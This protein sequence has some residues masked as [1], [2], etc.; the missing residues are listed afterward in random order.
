MASGQHSNCSKYAWGRAAQV[1]VILLASVMMTLTASAVDRSHEQV[2]KII[3]Q[4]QRADYEGDRSSLK[5]LH[6]KLAPFAEN[7]VLAAPVRYWR[8]FALWRRAINGFNDNVA[9]I[10]L[11]EDLRHALDEF[12]QAAK[13]DPTFV[14][15]KI[16]ALSCV[17]LLGYSVRRS[18]NDP[19]RIQEFMAQAKQLRIEV[20]AVAPENP[21]FL[22]VMG[23]NIW[24]TPADRGGGQD[25]AIEMYEKGLGAIRNR[26]TSASDPLEPSWGEP[27]LLMNLA[28]SS[29]HKSEPDL[30]AAEQY[31]RSALKLVPYWHYVRDILMPQIQEAKRKTELENPK[32]MPSRGR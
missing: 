15:A 22:W 16:G 2:I 6:E 12:D 5:R 28:Y 31:A 11:Q 13:I 10:E 26:K 24:N 9:P 25:K 8:G 29:L 19:A 7:K 20:E 27:E 14:D 4:I 21:R 23:P 18:Q 32:L 30:N 3:T 17:S 1:V